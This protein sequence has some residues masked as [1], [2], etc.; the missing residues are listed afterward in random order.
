VSGS[1][2][3]SACYELGAGQ[4][5]FAPLGD[6]SVTRRYS[7]LAGVATYLPE[8]RL[9]TEELEARIREHSPAFDLPAGL[10]QRLTGVEYRHIRSPGWMASD[11]AVAAARKFVDRCR[12]GYR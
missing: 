11:L 4:M 2:V 12:L 6:E 1:V 8:P 5:L 7:R 9:S 10:I 3:E